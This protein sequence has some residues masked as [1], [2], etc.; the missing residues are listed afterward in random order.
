[1]AKT[2]LFDYSYK[3]FYGDG[4][5]KD[6]HILNY[7]Q[8]NFEVTD[9]VQKLYLTACLLRFYQQCKLYNDKKS[10]YALYMVEDPLL[11]FVGGSVTGKRQKTHDT[12][13]VAALKFFA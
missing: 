10:D 1:Y 9:D 5:G 11:V 7:S 13:V 2:V 4:F 8:D 6:F 12:D 3:F